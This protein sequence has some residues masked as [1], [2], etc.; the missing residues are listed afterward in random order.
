MEQPDVEQTHID[1]NLE[2]IKER[3][4]YTDDIKSFDKEQLISV[5]LALYND[6]KNSSDTNNEA[7][8]LLTSIKTNLADMRYDITNIRYSVSKINDTDKK[9]DSEEIKFFY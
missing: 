3:Y 6:L 8:D 2:E 5:I 1:N 9:S 4:G 7:L